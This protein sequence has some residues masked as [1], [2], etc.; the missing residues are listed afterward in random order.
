M[1]DDLL[2]PKDLK[3]NTVKNIF[4]MRYNA[5]AGA[6]GSKGNPRAYQVAYPDFN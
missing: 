5:E 4:E 1:D 2:Q 6:P 3:G